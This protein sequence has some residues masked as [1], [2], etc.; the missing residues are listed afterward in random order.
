M[1]FND[2]T[3][4]DI[5]RR[6]MESGVFSFCKA[7]DTFCPLG[8]WIVTP[9]EIPDP[10]DLAMELRVNGEPRQESHSGRM[11]V[12]IPEILVP[13]L[14]ARLLGG[15]RRLDRDRVRRCRVQ[16]GRGVALPAARRRDG[17]G[18][19]AHRR[20]AQPGH[21]VAG[22]ARRAGA[23]A[24]ALV[25]WPRDD[26]KLDRVRALM[27]EREL[28]ALVVRAPDNVVYLSNY[29]PMKGYDVVV[30]RRDG[31]LAL[32]RSRPQADD[33]ARTAWTDD[34]RL[35]AGY[36]P[37]D[38]RPPARARARG[39]AGGRPASAARA[40]RARALARHAGVRPHGRRADDLH[41]R[42]V[43]RLPGTQVDDATPL[44]AEARAI[45]TDAGDRA[46]A[47]RE[48]ARGA[49]MEHVRERLRPGMKE[50]EA[51]ALWEGY[52]HGAGT[53]YDGRVELARGVRA[54]LVRP[55]ASA[56]SR[57]P[58]T[59]R[60]RRTSRR[61]SRSGSASTA[62][63]ATT[64]R[65][66]CPAAHAEY[67]ELLELLLDVYDARRRALPPGR[68][69]GRARPPGPRAA[70]GGRLPG[71]AV[72]P[73]RARRRRPRARAA[74]RAPGRRRRAARGHGPGDRARRCTGP[75]A[76]ASASRTTILITA[77]GAEKTLPLPGRLPHAHMSQTDYFDTAA[78][79]YDALRTAGDL[80][81]LLSALAEAGGFAGAR[82]I[83]IGCGTGAHL[84]AFRDQYGADV[85]GIDASP[86]M[87]AE[88]RAKLP[89]ADLR[90][91][92]AEELPFPDASST[93]RS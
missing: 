45:K 30:F 54:R 33:A 7:I 31:H 18:D 49:A 83:D 64:R 67:D 14:G 87:L 3:A 1:I 77:D 50:S 59:A 24:R 85:S 52:V 21:L 22:R 91:G 92:L 38:P 42:L 6:E 72:A 19:R 17:G 84:R 11:S 65:T 16:R 69:P 70:R 82:L 9:D 53:G 88:A 80:S 73:D 15:R 47:D 51:A 44:L 48:R 79:R 32:T 71:P 55:R 26:A 76:A 57:P 62:T 63:G 81:R 86:Q 93:P 90:V 89:D 25:A 60:C 20:A 39:R 10:H 28:D 43:P 74:V 36:H 40:D 68:E 41:E 56:P 5:Q 66:S 35:F 34:V 4:R 75:A 37:D 8:P 78:P 29:W 58:A 23:A 13:L 12:T 61:S 2:I 27:A 46:H